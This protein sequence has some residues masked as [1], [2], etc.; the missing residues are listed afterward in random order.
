MPGQ[1]DTT[2]PLAGIDVC[3][4]AGGLGTR[5]Q[6]VLGD[7]P[8]LLAPIH[9][10]PFLDFLVDQVQQA[11]ARRLV[12]LLGH[13]ADQV[14]ACIN[15][16]PYPEMTIDWVV[17]AEPLGTAGAIRHAREQLNS[18]PVLIVNGDTWLDLDF[19]ALCKAHRNDGVTLAGVMVDDAGRYGSLDVSPSGTLL[20]FHEKDQTKS[21]PTLINGGFGLY[22]QSALTALMDCQGPSL[23]QDFLSLATAPAT[24]VVN[25][26]QADFID[27]GTPEAYA[28]AERIL[29]RLAHAG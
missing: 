15:K 5:I 23:E 12:L 28:S 16:Q 27:F 7:C 9:G 17:E 6:G 14:M 24:R 22:S 3:V 13:L 4:L 18:D 21:G 20:G 11:G 19:W 25:L 26:G 2:L 29:P 1:Y 8:K 10:R